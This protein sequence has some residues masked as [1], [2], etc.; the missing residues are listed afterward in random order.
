MFSLRYRVAA[1]DVL[2]YEAPE[3]QYQH[4]LAIGLI[5]AKKVEM[6]DI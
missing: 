4:L 6:K 1:P 2:Y 5:E 3:V